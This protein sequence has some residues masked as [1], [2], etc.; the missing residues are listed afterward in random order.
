MTHPGRLAGRVAMVTGAARGQGRSHA[1]RLAAEGADVV[2]ID[3]LEDIAS[4]PYRLATKADLDET[5]R[6]VEE[7]GGKVLCSRADVRDF[8]EVDAVAAEAAERFGRLDI[9]CANAGIISYAS[10]Q[11]LSEQAWSDVIGV[12]LTGVWHTLKACVPHMLSA[13]HGGS[14]VIT[15]SMAGL[16]GLANTAHYTAAKHGVVGLMK[17]FAAE[18][19]TQGIRVNC[20]HPTS[21]NTD[22]LHNEATYNVFRP[23]FEHAT[24]EDAMDGFHF[25]NSMPTPWVEPSDVSDAVAWLASDESRFVTGISLP[26]DAGFLLR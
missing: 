8:D 18:L 11:A 7:A 5:A 26:V 24:L 19:A 2:A 6:L 21:V 25:V 9:V 4:V 15:S 10:G 14:I 16:K 20:V 1:V 12:N 3:L 22:M 17:V 23:G 13:G